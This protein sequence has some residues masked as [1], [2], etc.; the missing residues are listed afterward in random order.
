MLAV[1]R[2]W[3][4]AAV[5]IAKPS[6]AVHDSDDAANL[7]RP[8]GLASGTACESAASANEVAWDV[9]CAGAGARSAKKIVRSHVEKGA[10]H[11]ESVRAT[12]HEAITFLNI[13]VLR[14]WSQ[15][16]RQRTGCRSARAL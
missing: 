15:D 14:T 2:D 6:D 11:G 4:S 8:D 12:S 10:V 16:Q 13:G 9:P 1:R 5:G 7:T 3:V